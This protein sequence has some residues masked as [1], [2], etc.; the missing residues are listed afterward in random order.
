VEHAANPSELIIADEAAAY[1]E[2]LAGWS[3]PMTKLFH[4]SHGC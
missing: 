3:I 2:H 4:R 1:V